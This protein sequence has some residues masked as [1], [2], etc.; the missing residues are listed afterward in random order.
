MGNLLVP[1]LMVLAATAFIIYNYKRRSSAVSADEGVDVE[2]EAQD[3][4]LTGEVFTSRQVE[5]PGSREEESGHAVA[6]Y[7]TRYPAGGPRVRKWILS[8]HTPGHLTLGGH[9]IVY[10]YFN[11]D[12]SLARD[13]YIHPQAN[14]GG[15]SYVK[16]RVRYF[17]ERPGWP[18]LEHYFRV[19]GTMAMESNNRGEGLFRSF[20]KDGTLKSVYHPGTAAGQKGF[21]YRLDGET[22]WME[23]DE[24][25]NKRAH[26][27]LDGNPVDLRFTR[28][29]V[30]GGYSMGPQSE[31]FHVSNDHFVRADGSRAYKQSWFVRWDENAN[32][33]AD[34]LGALLIYDET[35]TTAVAEYFLELR[36]PDMPRFIKEANFYNPDGTYLT[37]RYRSPGCRAYEEL[38]E[39]DGGEVL[40]RTEFGTDDV[41]H[42]PLD[43]V[44]FQGFFRNVWGTYDDDSHDV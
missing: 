25:G 12:G 32:S 24:Q 29:R 17:D 26:F 36:G 1:I 15:G 6:M 30:V 14:L 10:E 13:R 41:F 28:E 38:I 27:D 4:E 40:E 37:R 23:Q 9:N 22:V 44:L 39:N 31:P 19:D 34:T 7:E 43:E 21:L 5:Y 35:G 33:I 20:R 3:P 16:E 18:A 11:E 8:M 2:S 42:E